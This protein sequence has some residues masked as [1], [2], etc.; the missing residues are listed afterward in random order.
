MKRLIIAMVLMVYGLASTG[1]VVHLEYCCGKLSDISLEAAK[2]DECKK[3][4]LSGKS[5]CD[6]KQVHLKVSG[7]QELMAKWSNSLKQ[8]AI[9]PP[10]TFADFRRPL[11][12][13]RSENFPTGP[14]I[15][16]S[17]VPLFLQNCL[18]LI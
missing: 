9:A 8:H 6:S 11:L 10:S 14:P 3:V 16:R 15:D 2:K 4:T 17:T 5:C 13:K 12:F 1:A 7:E 18:F